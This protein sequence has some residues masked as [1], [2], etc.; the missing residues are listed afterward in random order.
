[1]NYDHQLNVCDPEMAEEA[2]A[3]RTWR[4]MCNEAVLSSKTW[5]ESFLQVASKA[6]ERADD[7]AARAAT[8]RFA[9]WVAE[10]PANGLKRQRLFSRCATGW[11]AD[12][13]DEQMATNFSELDDLE[14]I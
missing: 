8:T 14:G 3:F 5:V 2:A 10:G 4:Y 11:V 6:A 7:S 13:T 12:Q 1:M 9:E